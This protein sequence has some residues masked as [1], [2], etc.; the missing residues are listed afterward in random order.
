VTVAKVVFAG[1]ARDC[2]AHLPAVL[3]NLERLSAACEAAAFVFV[4]NDSRDA[5]RRLLERFGAGRDNFTLFNLAGLGQLPIRTLRLEFARNVY[6]DFVRGEPALADFDSLCVLD[7]DDTG[8]YP[9]A[10][11]QFRAALAYLAGTERCAAVFANQLGPYYDLWA[12]RHPQYCPGDAWYEV[13][14]FARRH[15]CSDQEAFAQ[16]FA[17]RVRTFAPDARPVEVDSAFGGLGVYRL[18]YVR[19]SAN[20]YLGSCVHAWREGGQ[21][22]AFRMQQCEHVHFHSGLRQLG[23]RLF[24][25][26]ALINAVTAEGVTFPASAYRQ[27]CF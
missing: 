13:L 17:K 10:V 25:L 1:A 5:T 18:D 7:M 24:I 8:A 21:L 11:E 20:P 26:P 6:L 2:A 19:R 9:L 27:L 12:L 23:G 16:T 22:A 15:G 14:S 4:E 3:T